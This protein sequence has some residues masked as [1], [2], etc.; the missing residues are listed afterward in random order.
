MPGPYESKQGDQSLGRRILVVQGN[1][2][3]SS[4][5]QSLAESYASAARKEGHQVQL[6]T[7]SDLKFD[8]ILHHGYRVI[9]ELEPDL[10]SVQEY[11]TWAQ[12]IVFVYPTWWG[13]VPA[14]LKGLLDRM[15][16]P[17]FAFKYRKN[18]PLWDKLLSGKTARLI[19]TSD[20][21]ALWNRWVT[22]DPSV[23]MM[24]K[25]VLEFC[26]ISPVAVTRI[27]SVKFLDEK[28]RLKCLSN[29][30]QMGSRAR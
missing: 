4:F 21:P 27:G 3:K 14:L 6:V 2:D 8:P 7:V 13:A 26:G 16:L 5:C 23:R 24:K 28:K 10:K 18:S 19:V 1:P 15:L 22:G 25:T 20:A 29:V 11:F 12:H 30:A 17:G 9:Q